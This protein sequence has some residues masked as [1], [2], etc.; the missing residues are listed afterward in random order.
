MSSILVIGQNRWGHGD[1]LAQAKKAFR[2]QGARL[3][4]GYTVVEF[5]DGQAFQGVDQ[6]GRVHWV[7]DDNS[8]REPTSYD[9]ENGRKVPS[10]A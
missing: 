6:L 10:N 1:T 4:D 2:A 9:V 3:S 7:N 5:A 8:T